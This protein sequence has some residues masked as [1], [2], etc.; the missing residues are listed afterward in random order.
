MM[1]GP[2]RVPASLLGAI[3]FTLIGLLWGGIEVSSEDLEMA[4]GHEEDATA[5]THK[6]AF[7]GNGTTRLAPAF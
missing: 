4:R 7:A 2:V 6:D 5:T 3:T 1:L